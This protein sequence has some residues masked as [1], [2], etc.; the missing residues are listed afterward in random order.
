[1][2]VPSRPRTADRASPRSPL[3]SST[4]FLLSKAGRTSAARIA[5]RLEPLGLRPKHLAVLSF[6]DD[7]PGSSQQELG[8]RLGFDASAVVA[9]IDELERQRL[10]ERRQDPRDR[11]RHAVHL[12]RRGRTMLAQ[13][14]AA[15]AEHEETLLG[16]L[17]HE[18]RQTLHDLLLR[19]V[20]AE[21]PT[22]APVV[23]DPG[24]R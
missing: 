6:L 8:G 17:D 1:M 11:R 12:T 5:A 13:A 21:D 7:A 18:E 10:A 14:R 16:V 24:R 19:I 9:L 2:S 15:A 23:T 3:A 20:A 22:L 4:A